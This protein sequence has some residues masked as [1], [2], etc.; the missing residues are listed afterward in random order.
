M[1]ESKFETVS[2]LVDSYQA[3]EDTVL[4]DMLKDNDMSDTWQRY[5]LIGDV[6]RDELP[7]ELDFDLTDTIANAIAEEPTV[8]APTAKPS[9]KETL[10]AKVVQFSKP[11]GQVAIAASAAG[12]MV[13][14]VQQNVA[15]NDTQTPYQ[16]VDTGRAVGGIAEP[17]SLNFQQNSRVSQQPTLAEQQRKFHALLQDHKQQLKLTALSA[18]KATDTPKEEAEKSAK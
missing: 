17:V 6:M 15:Q 14:G 7:D 8:L 11:F 9:I 10:K 13:V 5:H 16:V 12:L 2:S 3:Q 4:Q 1:S 18:N